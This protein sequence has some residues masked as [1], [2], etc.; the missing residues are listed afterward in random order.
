MKSARRSK[1]NEM[2]FRAVNA[3]TKLKTGFKLLWALVGG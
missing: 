1:R 2:K 3:A